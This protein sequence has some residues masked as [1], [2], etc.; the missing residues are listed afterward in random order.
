MS[1]VRRYVTVDDYE[2]VARAALPP[3]VYDY[4]AGGAG[5]EWTLAQN[6]RAFD[7]WMFRPRYLRGSG[8]PDPSTTVLGSPVSF[9]VIVAPWAYQ[10]MARPDG[11]EATARAASAAGTLMVVST[12]AQ[13]K[14]V[15]V[16][17]AAGP[18]WW[19]LYV[20]EDHPVTVELLRRVVAAGYGAICL[21]VDV[22]VFG[23]RHRDT[24]SGFE[25]PIGLPA[26]DLPLTSSS[27]PASPG[28]TSDASARPRPACR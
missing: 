27:I 20:H 10:W 5:D 3:D 2:P 11:E 15:A 18:V 13:D 19:Q 6:R 7:R 17:P 25:M 23:L 8:T 28:T 21:T 1:D 4:F 14:L 9:P 22:P 26:S 16:A 12:T 24:R